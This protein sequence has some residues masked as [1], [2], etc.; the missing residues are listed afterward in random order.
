[1][2]TAVVDHLIA[3]ACTV[4]ALDVGFEGWPLAGTEG[5]YARPLD[6]VNWQ[7]IEDAVEFA[8]DAMGGIDG[9]VHAAAVVDSIHRAHHFSRQDWDRELDVNLSAAFRL[10]QVSYPHLRAGGGR[11]VLVSSVAAEL[12]QPGQVAYAASKS[13]LL[14][15]MR[16][17]AVEWGS[18]GIACNVVMPGLVETPKVRGLPETVRDRYREQ[19]PL[20]RFASPDELAGVIAF[21]LSPTAAYINGA[22]IRMDG[23]LGLSTL[24]L[25]SGTGARSREALH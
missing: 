11:I 12:G 4:V 6:L 25:A 8:V 23:G 17:L 21:L 16:T 24:S 5:V 7:P 18:D 22:V 13:G 14:G 10:A 1:V 2:G 15:L 9:L 20:G 19:V 3:R